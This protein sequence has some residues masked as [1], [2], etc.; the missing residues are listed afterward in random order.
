[1]FL[2]NGGWGAWSSWSTCGVNCQKNRVRNCD[3]PVPQNGGR[4]CVG[5][6]T[7]STDCTGGNC[8]SKGDFIVVSGGQMDDGVI[9]VEDA[10]FDGC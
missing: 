5:A 3:N 7:T 9:G 1:M 8:K 4:N 6:G 2:V 10:G